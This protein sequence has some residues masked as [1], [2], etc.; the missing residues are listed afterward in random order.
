MQISHHPFLFGIIVLCAIVSAVSAAEVVVE[1]DQLVVKGF[2]DNIGLGAFS[3]VL[4]YDPAK[5]TV[6][7]VTFVDPF[8][9][10]TNIQQEEK[11]VRISGFTVQAQLTGDI[12]VARIVY[13]GEGLFDVYVSTFVNARGDTVATANPAYEGE[14]PISPGTPATTV[15]TVA[16]TTGAPTP[17]ATQQPVTPQATGTALT[18]SVDTP[19]LPQQQQTGAPTP[20][21]TTEPVM[22]ETG[23]SGTPA[24][25]P[26]AGSL[27]PPALAIFGFAIVLFALKRNP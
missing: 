26:A 2:D 6:T 27:L 14:A 25:T 5:T 16:P 19:A 3:V 21:G 4:G 10:A 24:Q 9:G 22:T 15:S 13:E 23:S 1:S 8:T 11:T 7:E 18:G 12:P 17:T 20:Q